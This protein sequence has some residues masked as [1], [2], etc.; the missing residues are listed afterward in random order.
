MRIKL[1]ICVIFLI[2]IVQQFTQGTTMRVTCSVILVLCMT[3]KTYQ[4]V[5][6]HHIYGSMTAKGMA[7][8]L[9]NVWQH[10][11]QIYGTLLP[12][13]TY[14]SYEIPNI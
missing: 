11:C 10:G 3:E 14:S 9:P 8:R 4:E 2:N 12:I 7:A 13:H 6:N 1:W 5:T